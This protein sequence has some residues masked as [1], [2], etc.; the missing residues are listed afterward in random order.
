M[1]SLRKRS[2]GPAGQPRVGTQVPSPE[3]FSRQTIL[4]SVGPEGQ[5]KWSKASALLAGEGVTLQS[6][7]AALA[8]VGVSKLFLVSLGHFDSFSLTSQFPHLQVDVLPEETESLPE[9]S[10]VLVLT[11]DKEARR[12]FSRR[13]RH[14]A[15]PAFFTWPSG[16]G[17]ALF[18]ARHEGGQCPCLECFEVLNPKA[19]AGREPSLQRMIGAMAA[20]EALQWILRG[21]SPLEG[22]VWITSLERG[23]SFHHEVQPTYKCPARLLEEGAPVTP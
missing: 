6:A 8:A 22:K 9:T 11:E 19:F 3:K 7:A 12:R 15:R 18:T 21:G 17:F 13:L 10:A 4:P 20:S 23:I 1:A 5:D 14:H 2:S 16:S